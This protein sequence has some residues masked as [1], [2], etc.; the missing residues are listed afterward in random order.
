MY[1]EFVMSGSFCYC[2]TH[3]R[4]PTVTCCNQ[5]GQRLLHHDPDSGNG[6]FMPQ[7][8]T[9]PPVNY[10]MNPYG[11]IQN[12]IYI[13]PNVNIAPHIGSPY[14]HVNVVPVIYGPYGGYNNPN[15][16][17]GVYFRL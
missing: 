11:S 7:Y 16:P 4:K 1:F 12:G 2:P 17:H 5:C 14:G 9:R 15:V 6:G 10:G 8:G 13:N 3:G